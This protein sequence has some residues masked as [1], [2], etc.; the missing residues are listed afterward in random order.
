MEVEPRRYRFRILNACNSRFLNPRL[1]YA[2]GKKFPD[3]TEPDNANLGPGFVQIAAE[4]GFLPAPV[5]IDGKAFK[6]LLSPAERA[7]LIVTSQ[8]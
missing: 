2:K 4:G 6:L 8:R 7:D 1:V 5:P 3:N